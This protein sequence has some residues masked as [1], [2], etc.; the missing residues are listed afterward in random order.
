[1]FPNQRVLYLN[2][3]MIVTS[4]P[5]KTADPQNKRFPYCLPYSCEG[6]GHMGINISGAS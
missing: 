3:Y 6:G 5:L 4:I 1:M 2:A